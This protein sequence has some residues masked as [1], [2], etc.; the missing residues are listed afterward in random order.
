MRISDWSSDVCSSDLTESYQVAEGGVLVGGAAQG[1]LVGL[2]A[3]LIDAEDADVGDVVVGA[4]VDAAGDVD[5]DFADLLLAVET[6]EAVGDHLPDRS[7]A[8]VRQ[9]AI[10]EAGAGDHVGDPPGGDEMG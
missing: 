3:L 10:V 7:R 6:A 4:G 8:G 9:V 2:R 1:D 5:G